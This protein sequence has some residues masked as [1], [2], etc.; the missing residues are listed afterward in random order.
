MAHLF[1]HAIQ[2]ALEHDKGA[3][4]LVGAVVGAVVAWVMVVQVPET[5][6]ITHYGLDEVELSCRTASGVF[7]ERAEATISLVPV[8]FGAI[9]GAGIGLAIDAARFRD[10]SR[11]P[12]P[13][14]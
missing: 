10:K 3:L 9:A 14:V 7:A 5:C 1:W 4:A 12:M 2:E 6:F 8:W 13:P 11:P